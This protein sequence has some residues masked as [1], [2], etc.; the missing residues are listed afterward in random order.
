MT[1]FVSGQ[2]GTLPQKLKDL[3]IALPT[4]E[5][6]DSEGGKD[7]SPPEKPAKETAVAT[8][9]GITSS[10][11]LNTE[12]P[13]L[14]EN[15][16]GQINYVSPYHWQSILDDIKEVKEHLTDSYPPSHGGSPGDNVQSD[17]SFLFG[18]ESRATLAEILSSLPSQ[19]KCDTMLSS[20]FTMPFLILAIVHPDKFRREVSSC[21]AA[22]WNFQPLI[23]A[24]YEAF[25]V[26][27]LTAHPLWIAL[28]F[29]ILST[30]AGMRKISDPTGNTDPQLNPKIFQQ[31]CVQCLVLG[32]YATANEHALEAFVLHLQS[33]FVTKDEPPINPW[34]EMGTIIRLAFRMGY[35][36]DPTNLSRISVFEGEMRRRVWLNIVQTEAL[37]SFQTGFPSMI[38]VDYCD[39]QTP[40]NLHY[41]DLFINMTVLPPSRPLSEHTPA[42]YS[43]IKNSVMSVF[44]KLVAHTQSR[45]QPAYDKT[46]ALDAEMRAAYNGIPDEFKHRPISRSFMDPIGTIFERTTIELLYCKGLIILHRRYITEEPTSSTY[47]FSRRACVEA[48]L[49]ILTRQL[50]LYKACEPGGRLHDY[51]T[52]VLALPNH[53]YLLAAMVLCLDLSVR[54]RSE[55]AYANSGRDIE[56]LDRELQA[57]KTSQQVWTS[58]DSATPEARTASLAI[59]VMVRKLTG[60]ST[61]GPGM[62]SR[63]TSDLATGPYV[64]N[65]AM[66]SSVAFPGGNMFA[67]EGIMDQPFPT[68]LPWEDSMAHMIDGTEMIN[69]V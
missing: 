45:S 9:S 27:P 23:F 49:A 20:Y 67:G 32:K 53:D 22:E 16:D 30:A 51:R 12:A 37:L 11:P 6:D 13:F 33:L 34:F 2:A 26:S 21:L 60:V 36:R 3:E 54:S 25:W 28:L 24:Q 64:G 50:D 42:R 1:A 61:L 58:F 41:S 10:E 17:A 55:N 65:N 29:A 4:P 19:A 38:P 7:G 8:F 31:R 57:L 69:W 62:L 63:K 5:I 59:D 14:Q 35:H 47:E 46:L 48:A 18:S 66:L 15:E 56:Q 39:T 43:I 40:R 68:Q 52:M 44:R